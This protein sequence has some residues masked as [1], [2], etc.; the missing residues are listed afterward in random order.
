MCTAVDQ[1][2][3]DTT[4]VAIAV[5]QNEWLSLSALQIGLCQNVRQQM[6]SKVHAGVDNTLH[7]KYVVM[8]MSNSLV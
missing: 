7:S 6:L 1:C 5:Y 8:C 2:Q 4:C 3:V